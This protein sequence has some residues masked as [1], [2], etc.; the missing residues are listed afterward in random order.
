MPS[1]NKRAHR[2]HALMQ[3]AGKRYPH[4]DPGQASGHARAE[5]QVLALFAELCER[6]PD[7]T[8]RAELLGVSVEAEAV[9]SR[10]VGLPVLRAHRRAVEQALRDAARRDG[11]KGG[12]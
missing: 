10:G 12:G 2:T 1:R 11:S 6:V 4:L 7:A 9:W 5:R 8:E 3:E